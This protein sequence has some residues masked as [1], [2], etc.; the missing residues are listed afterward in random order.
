MFNK[1]I[2]NVLLVIFDSTS[3]SIVGCYNPHSTFIDKTKMKRRALFLFYAHEL[4]SIEQSPFSRSSNPLLPEHKHLAMHEPP[5]AL[6]CAD[7]R[8]SSF[9]FPQPNPCWV[10]S[11]DFLIVWPILTTINLTEHPNPI[12]LHMQVERPPADASFTIRSPSSQPITCLLLQSRS[13]F[14]SYFP[15]PIISQHS[16]SILLH[17]HLQHPIRSNLT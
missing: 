13:N 16:H 3:R 17:L 1:V 9:E 10:I 11:P 12:F 6:H 5:V 7:V 2:I 14:T 8:S 15:L 4:H